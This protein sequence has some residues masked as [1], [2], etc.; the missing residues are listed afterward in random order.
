MKKII[1]KTQKELDKIK[2]D[3]KGEIVIAGYVKIFNRLFINASVTLGVGGKISS[4]EGGKISSMQ[5]GEIYWIF[6]TAVLVNVSMELKNIFGRAA[7]LNAQAGAKITTR[8][9]NIVRYEKSA[10]KDIELHLSENTTEIELPEFETN[11]KSFAK[12]YLFEVKGTK[13]ILYKAVHKVDGKYLS[14]YN[15]NFEYKVGDDITNSLDMENEDSCGIGLHVSFK[16]WAIGFGGGWSDMALLECEVDVNDI[17]VGKDCDG[18]V[19]CSRLKVL[20]EV[21]KEEWAL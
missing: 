2:D 13:A 17:F 3:F 8:G 4:M 19:R 15:R 14:N 10:K 16:G 11:F 1:V 20:R 18:K 5:G 7:I 21:P 12:E 9:H 6:G